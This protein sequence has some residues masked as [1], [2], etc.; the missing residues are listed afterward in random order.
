MDTAE[1]TSKDTINTIKETQNQPTTTSSTLHSYISWIGT[2]IVT[3]IVSMVLFA[4][5]L[6]GSVFGLAMIGAS[7]L[8]SSATL[9][10]EMIIGVIVV[11]LIGFSSF[12]LYV[13]GFVQ[14]IARAFSKKDSATAVVNGISLALH[15]IPIL[16]FILLLVLALFLPADLIS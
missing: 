14:S 9:S 6:V 7:M 12:I 11:V 8:S 4:T 3:F 15:C 13:L 16:G 5:F 2:P 10:T 1:D